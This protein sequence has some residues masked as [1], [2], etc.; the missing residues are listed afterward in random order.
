MPRVFALLGGGGVQGE[1]GVAIEEVDSLAAQTFSSS[2][3]IGQRF[4][5][6]RCAI[7]A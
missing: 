1:A 7:L 3:A 4:S 6:A 2:V 5:P